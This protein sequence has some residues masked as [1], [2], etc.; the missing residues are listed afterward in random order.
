LSQWWKVS[1][2]WPLQEEQHSGT[3]DALAFP[4]SIVILDDPSPPVQEIQF[5]TE[6]ETAVILE[7]LEE[8]SLGGGEFLEATLRREF[9]WHRQHCTT[10]ENEEGTIQYK[11]ETMQQYLDP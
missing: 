3:T 2:N 4:K 11:S 9:C 7:R 8:G 5:Q 10:I 6:Q 1:A